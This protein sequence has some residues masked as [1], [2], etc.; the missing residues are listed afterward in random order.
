[1]KGASV[2][3]ELPN[4]FP[5]A[6]PPPK[7][8]REAPYA[9]QSAPPLAGE[10]APVV[11]VAALAIMGAALAAVS[12]SMALAPPPE[13]FATVAS[14]PAPPPEPVTIV[15]HE[16]APPPTIIRVQVPTPTPE[17][18]RAPC[19]D[20]VTLMFA[21]NSAAPLAAEAGVARLRDWF[22]HHAD[23]KLFV[24]GHADSGGSEDHNLAL[25]FA[26]AKS[27]AALLARNG[28]PS[29]RVTVRAAGATEAA[30]NNDA[31]N[32]RV[33]AGVEGLTA[34]K[35]AAGAPEHP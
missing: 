23:A 3:A 32:R 19:F 10:G 16:P 4:A 34:C 29:S 25:S 7:M 26:R 2:N 35:S 33:V 20:S 17:A 5:P 28:V 8:E 11:L 30:A 22:E 18:P 31:R 1:M 13:P 24:E 9:F 6:P 14:E 27:V 21:R 12:A 15:V